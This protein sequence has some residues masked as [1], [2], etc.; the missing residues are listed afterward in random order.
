MGSLYE[1]RQEN[2]GL[3]LVELIVAF[4]MAAVISATI[5]G[6]IAYS[7]RVYSRQVRTTEVQREIQ[8]T[9]NQVVD[10]AMSADWFNVQGNADKTSYVAF[11]ELINN[12]GTNYFVGEIFVAGDNAENGASADRFNIYMNRYSESDALEVNSVASE[13]GSLK[14]ELYLIGSD[15][16][17]FL[18]QYNAKPTDAADKYTNPISFGIEIEFARNSMGSEIKKSVKDEVS[19]RNHLDGVVIVNGSSYSLDKN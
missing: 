13:A 2:K 11:G 3:S 8:T 5:A 16:T 10:S 14:D 6:L 9:L 4:A 12:G 1:L 15:A 19:L 7:V 18:V 17:K